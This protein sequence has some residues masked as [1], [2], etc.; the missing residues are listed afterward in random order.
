MLSRLPVVLGLASLAVLPALA[1]SGCSSSKRRDQYYDKD[2]GTDFQIP[3]AAGFPSQLLDAAAADGAAETGVDPGAA[4]V[5]PDT[6]VEDLPADAPAQ[7]SDSDI[8]S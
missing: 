8:D 1:L 3:D 7:E 2:A 6:E 4:D 5:A